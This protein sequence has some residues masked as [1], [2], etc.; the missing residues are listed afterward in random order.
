MLFFQ[1]SPVYDIRMFIAAG[2]K[3]QPLTVLLALALLGALVISAFRIS[4]MAPQYGRRRMLWFF[5]SLFFTAIP[6]TL[7]FWRDYARG[8]SARESLPSLGRRLKKTHSTRHEDPPEH[9]QHCGEFLTPDDI[10]DNNGNRGV[11]KKCRNCKMKLDR[12]HFA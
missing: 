5:I 6:A 4:R 8:M 2:S 7:I 1:A 11:I 12:E 3:I 9:C 10:E